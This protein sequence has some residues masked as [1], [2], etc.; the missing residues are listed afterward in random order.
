MCAVL[1]VVITMIQYSH[2]VIMIR[3]S[4]AHPLLVCTFYILLGFVQYHLTLCK[5]GWVGDVRI[6]IMGFWMNVSSF[7]CLACLHVCLFFLGNILYV[8][9]QMFLSKESVKD[10]LISSHPKNI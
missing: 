9:L 3:Y 4:H 7:L 5:S 6:G 1:S 8:L 2:W 10:H